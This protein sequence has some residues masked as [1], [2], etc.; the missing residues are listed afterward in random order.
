MPPIFQILNFKEKTM[1]TQREKSKTYVA[2]SGLSG[3]DELYLLTKS[4][5]KEF[6]KLYGEF[7]DEWENHEE[8]VD[9]I[10]ENGTFVSYCLVVT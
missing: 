9:W 5:L 3:R 10:L 7:E 2:V 4:K 1:L 8:A 6:E